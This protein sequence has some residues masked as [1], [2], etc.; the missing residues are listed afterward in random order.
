ME[1]YR[2]HLKP[3]SPPREPT[4]PSGL[5]RPTP[6]CRVGTGRRRSALQTFS[7]HAWRDRLRPVRLLVVTADAEV[8]PP[9][10]FPTPGGTGSA[11]SVFSS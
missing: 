6:V 1:R 8:G 2:H 11:R 10:L 7:P 5:D 9:D 3:P 4:M